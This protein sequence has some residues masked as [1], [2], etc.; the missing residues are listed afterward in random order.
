MSPG[1]A[2]DERFAV[3]VPI[4]AVVTGI[5]MKVTP[6]S[7]DK[8]RFGPLINFVV[9]VAV[10]VVVDILWGSFARMSVLKG[11]LVAASTSGLYDTGKAVKAIATNRKDE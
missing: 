5:F 3:Y 1:V 8:K 6:P 11:L 2:I 7:F 9:G 10:V 4:I